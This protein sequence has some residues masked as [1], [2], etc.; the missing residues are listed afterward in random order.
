MVEIRRE[1]HF[2]MPSEETEHFETF[3]SE[4]EIPRESMA[5]TEYIIE[6]GEAEEIEDSAQIDNILEK[7]PPIEYNDR[8]YR[9]EKKPENNDQL[10]HDESST[11][12]AAYLNVDKF[13]K[14]AAIRKKESKT[15]NLDKKTKIVNMLLQEKRKEI[16]KLK[17]VSVQKVISRTARTSPTATRF[18]SR[19]TSIKN[20]LI[21]SKSNILNT[22]H[23][24]KKSPNFN[25]AYRNLSLKLVQNSLKN[26]PGQP[27]VLLTNH[28]IQKIKKVAN[29]NKSPHS[30]SV[31]NRLYN[32]A[33]KKVSDYALKLEQ[34]KSEKEKS[35]ASFR[36]NLIAKSTHLG[37]RRRS[38]K[39][40]IQDM[41]SFNQKK[42][43]KILEQL[44]MKKV[45]ESKHTNSF[46]KRKGSRSPD[47]AKL[48]HLYENGLRK[49]RMRSISPDQNPS[50]SS[51][52]P[53]INKKSKKMIREA[54]VYDILYNDAKRRD[55]SLE[56]QRNTSHKRFMG[57][58]KFSNDKTTT[59]YMVSRISKELETV[60]YEFQI[61]PNSEDLEFS[62]LVLIL[63]KMGYV[64]T[65]IT[66]QEK[67][68]I[69]LMW[70]LLKGEENKEIS[71]RN[72]FIF[73]L[74]IHQLNFEEVSSG[75]EAT[76]LSNKR[77]SQDDISMV[78]NS[79]DQSK[80]SKDQN[81]DISGIKFD[82]ESKVIVVSILRHS[83]LRKNF[84]LSNK[85][86][87]FVQ[88]KASTAK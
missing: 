46:F 31:Y 56:I 45:E 4:M 85:F 9:S 66:D 67:E 87:T 20:Q 13:N 18:S 24:S 47:Y 75:N 37:D 64:S 52:I 3:E 36:P 34:N 12:A 14:L 60:L 54:E 78:L 69:N 30:Q 72:L 40:F 50:D 32:T 51:I 83:L 61:N 21:G 27:A 10:Q 15:S 28:E 74:K 7:R 71:V 16:E 33:T 84:P 55:R 86:I 17:K 57:A 25:T 76:V 22:S 82:N 44:R 79:V 2:R 48:K 1:T 59:G 19:K 5:D 73:L 70:K 58:R 43:S 65:Q 11:E 6:E 88:R 77:Q 35:E 41:N 29:I 8:K 39:D 53:K 62:E 42:E 68:L 23:L 81:H 80:I 38:M 26:S 49:Q 63:T